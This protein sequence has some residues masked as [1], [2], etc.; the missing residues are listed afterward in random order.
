MIKVFTHSDL[1]GLGCAYVIKRYYE[2]YEEY[3]SVDV[4][5]QYCQYTNIDNAISKF[6]HSGAINYYDEVFITDLSVNIATCYEIEACGDDK[7]TLIDHHINE[8][9]EHLNE[10]EWCHRVG[11]LDGEVR[12]ATYLTAKHLGMLNDKFIKDFVE[13][14]DNWDVWKWKDKNDMIAKDMS[15]LFY[16]LGKERFMA[17][18][19]KQ[20]DKDHFEFNETNRLLLDIRN[21]E[22][23]RHL[24]VANKNMI[25]YKWGNYTIGVIFNDKFTSELG[26]D[27]CEQNEDI[28][29]VALI[30]F[31]TGISFRGARED[32]HLGNI[33]QEIGNLVELKGQGHKQAS[34]ISFDDAIRDN[35]I[36]YLI[37]GAEPWK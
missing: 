27:L 3:T 11:E 1:D 10:F 9:T 12:S 28:D 15:D 34:G 24:Y 16:I 5:V 31:K 17:E 6:I 30:N 26:N 36:R 21:E 13:H 4:Q 8:G 22:Y 37:K 23:E 25:R 20:Q 33:A 7:F 35:I 29:F 32:V 14:V 19:Y 2:Q 18:L